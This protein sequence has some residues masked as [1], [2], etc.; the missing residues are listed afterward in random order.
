MLVAIFALL[1][2]LV[3]DKAT[4]TK[5]GAPVAVNASTY[6]TVKS[7]AGPAKG[8]LLGF[9]LVQLTSTARLPDGVKITIDGGTP[10]ESTP[11]YHASQGPFVPSVSGNNYNPLFIPMSCRFKSS[12]L[13]EVKGTSSPTGTCYCTAVW[14][15]EV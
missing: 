15:E 9:W 11:L 13:L 6:V 4:V 12:F 10:V 2:R 3:R 5:F 8:H 14:S 1:Q 7:L